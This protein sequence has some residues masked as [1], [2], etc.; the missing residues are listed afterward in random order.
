M[1]NGT[2]LFLNF[3]VATPTNSPLVPPLPQLVP[4]MTKAARAI[5]YIFLILNNSSLAFPQQNNF[6]YNKIH[7][8]IYD[9]T[10]PSAFKHNISY[11]SKLKTKLN[12]YYNDKIKHLF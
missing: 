4:I 8:T 5:K 10:N 2:S 9:K 3:L 11:K 6:E 12:D 7:N 1:P